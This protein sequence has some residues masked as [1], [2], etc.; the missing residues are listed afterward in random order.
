MRTALASQFFSPDT[1]TNP[2]KLVEYNLK[3]Y[4]LFYVKR[5]F[6]QISNDIYQPATERD[7]LLK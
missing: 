5:I 6:R 3:Y 4:L 1:S 7:I 2:A